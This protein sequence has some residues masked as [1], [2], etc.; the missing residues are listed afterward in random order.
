MHRITEMISPYLN[1]AL[2]K[3]EVLAKYESYIN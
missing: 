2:K 1:E 3:K